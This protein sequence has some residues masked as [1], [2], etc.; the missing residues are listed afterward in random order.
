MIISL[1]IIALN[2]E[3]YLPLILEDVLS[4]TF[5]LDKI[6]FILIN[7]LSTDET[8]NIMESFREKNKSKFHD[9]RVLQNIG[10]WQSNGWNLFI[11]NAVGDIL[12]KIDAH[13]HIPNDFIKKLIDAMEEGYF[14]VLGGKRPTILQ[15]K[16]NW[17]EILLEA[18][19]SLFG[20][21][22]AVFRTSDKA[23]YVKSVFHGAYRREVF[24]KAGKFNERLRRTEDNEIHW[25]IR[26]NGF[27][28]RYDPSIVSYQY[29][30]P[31]LRKMMKQKFSNGVWIGK[32]FWICPQ[33]LS[34]YHFVPGGFVGALIVT[35]FLSFFTFIPLFVLLGLYGSF[36]LINTI[37]SVVKNKKV[38]QI[39][40]IILFPLLHISYGIGTLLG[41]LTI[42]N[43]RLV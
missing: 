43:K 40:L 18:E 24:E 25:R 22:I 9:I 13:A 3:Q 14:D 6:D 35:A 12:I 2:E 19:N 23:R 31:T 27:L 30:R 20:S 38:S 32:T 42:N 39:I 8:K 16:T 29:A 21:G 33:C 37:L 11:D 15:E 1:G 36:C 34:L 7:S 17:S 4:Q 10:K 5:P 28:I 26:K 41:L